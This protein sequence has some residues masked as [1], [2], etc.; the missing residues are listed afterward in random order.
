MNFLVLN[1]VANMCY[2][3]MQCVFLKKKQLTCTATVKI[4]NSNIQIPSQNMILYHFT[5]QYCNKYWSP[6]FRYFVYNKTKSEIY[7]QL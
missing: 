4:L 7:A 3:C 2:I 6:I 1:Q 5:T